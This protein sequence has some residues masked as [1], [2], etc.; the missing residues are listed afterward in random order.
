M[1]LVLYVMTPCTIYMLVI[2]SACGKA[3]CEELYHV[4]LLFFFCTTCVF[5]VVVS[6]HKGKKKHIL[7]IWCIVFGVYIFCTIHLNSI[8]KT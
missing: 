4:F 5:K 6:I 1:I 8:C 2:G 3:T 7:V